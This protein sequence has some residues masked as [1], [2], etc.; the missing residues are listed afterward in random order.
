LIG[1]LSVVA[2]SLDGGMMVDKRRSVQSAA[3]AAALAAA[4]D[5]Y[6]NWWMNL[7]SGLDNWDRSNFA[8]TVEVPDGSGW[9]SPAATSTSTPSSAEARSPPAGRGRRS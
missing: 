2:L 1:V 7:V 6:A 4:D 9:W 8:G 5:L 3:D